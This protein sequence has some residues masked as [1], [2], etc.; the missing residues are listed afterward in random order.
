MRMSLRFA[1]FRGLLLLFG[2]NVV[3]GC[4]HEETSQKPLTPVGVSAVQLYEAGGGVRYSATIT[5]NTQV[6]LA[7]KSGGYI[8]SILQVR[9]TDRRMRNVQGGDWVSK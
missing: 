2:V 4:R 7:F 9:G 1:R 6:D 8:D 3:T 5:P